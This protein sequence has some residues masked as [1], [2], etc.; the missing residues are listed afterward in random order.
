MC[1]LVE[2]VRHTSQ[3]TDVRNARLG[4]EDEPSVGAHGEIDERILVRQLLAVGGLE[5]KH[6]TTL[7]LSG[8]VAHRHV[9]GL[10]EMRE[11]SAEVNVL[12]LDKRQEVGLAMEARSNGLVEHPFVCQGRPLGFTFIYRHAVERSEKRHGCFLSGIQILVLGV[13]GERGFEIDHIGKGKLQCSENNTF[14]LNFKLLS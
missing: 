11:E 8:D 6:T 12:A 13:S 10:G 4:V 14:G 2:V 1:Q 7:G 9:L 5:D 3:R